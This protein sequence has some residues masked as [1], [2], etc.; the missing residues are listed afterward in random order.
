MVSDRMSLHFHRICRLDQITN[1]LDE[2]LEFS[3]RV[4][5]KAPFCQPETWISWME[6]YRE[7]EPMVF[8]LRRADK[9]IALLPMYRKGRA[10]H[11]A[12]HD[13]LDYQEIA[14]HSVSDAVELILRVIASEGEN[15]MSLSFGKVSEHSLL[16]AALHDPALRKIA[17]VQSR[18]QSICSTVTYA[19]NGPRGVLDALSSRQRKDHNAAGRKLA[20]EFPEHVV[21]HNSGTE[22][23]ATRLSAIGRL[24]QESQIRKSGTSIFADL[25]FGEFIQRQAESGAPIRVSILWDRPDGE[26]LAFNVAYFSGD[27]FYYYLTAYSGRHAHLSCGRWLLVESLRHAS[28]QMDGDFI[29]FDLLSGEDAYKSR[30]AKSFYEVSRFQVIP[31]SLANLPRLA[32]YSAVYQLKGVKNRL[33]SRLGVDRLTSLEHEDVALPS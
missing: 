4:N 6:V 27:T 21:E 22:I 13:L 31:K 29:R 2:W 26:P 23:D 1:H 19:I 32:A 7:F 8:E 20:A 10:L 14:A 12:C 24:H 11:M 15:G 16:S 18:Y 33:R 5:L 28:S 3:N 25:R 17:S 30:W 9:L